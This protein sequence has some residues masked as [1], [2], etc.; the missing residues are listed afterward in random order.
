MIILPIFI[1]KI[2]ILISDFSYVFGKA[3][4]IIK[5]CYIRKLLFNFSS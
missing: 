1:F 4:Y 5:I 3:K 2:D